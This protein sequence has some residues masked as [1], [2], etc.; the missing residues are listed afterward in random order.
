MTVGAALAAAVVLL[1]VS[2]SV[3]DL[4]NDSQDRFTSIADL[5]SDISIRDH[6][7][8]WEVAA[9]IV[10]EHPVVG[11][12]QETFPD[13]FPV[14]SHEV[15]PAD[16]STDLDRFRVESPHNF[17]LAVATGAGLPAMVAFG[18]VLLATVRLSLT[19]V[20]THAPGGRLLVA[21]P[22]SVLGYAVTNSFISA[23]LS[24]TWVIWLL[25]GAAVG[26][27]SDH[28][29]SSSPAPTDSTLFP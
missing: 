24:N 17:L 27:T 7:D 19:G 11:T 16:R 6:R 3:R 9:R 18:W 1:A 21:V 10:V 28:P 8:I 12:G 20:R 5:S 25:M 22:I 29:P 13:V 4:A 2:P 15:L 14:Y 26:L 23:D